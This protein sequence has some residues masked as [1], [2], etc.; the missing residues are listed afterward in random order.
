MPFLTC[1]GGKNTRHRKNPSARYLSSSWLTFLRSS[2]IRTLRP[3][4]SANTSVNSSS[5]YRLDPRT[6]IPL[7]SK[8]IS[9]TARG[10]GVFSGVCT[11]RSN[12][13]SEGRGTGK[14]RREIS[15]A[16]PI[17]GVCAKVCIDQAAL[18]SASKTRRF[19]RAAR[20]S[21]NILGLGGYLS[22]I[23]TSVVNKPLS[24]RCKWNFRSGSS[25][26]RCSSDL[27]CATAAISPALSN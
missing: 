3:V 22:S 26:Y 5:L 12:L 21:S 1:C 25:G 4:T 9:S 6:R 11:R 14:R 16:L 15:D 17:L 2:S 23:L 24:I 20:H 13:G 7:I 10:V 19:M 18:T 27:N 8:S